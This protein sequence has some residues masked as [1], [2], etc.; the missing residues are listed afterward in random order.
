MRR[1]DLPLKHVRLRQGPIEYRAAGPIDAPVLIFVHGVLAND[2]LWSA[3]VPTLSKSYRC[4]VPIWPLGAHRLAMN[5]AADLTPSGMLVV[6]ED[7]MDAL[8]VERATF[9]GNDSGG[10]LCQ[11]LVAAHPQR[12]ERL[13]LTSSDAYTIWLPWMFKYLEFAAF[14]PGMLYLLAQF[15]R[16]RWLRRL[17]FAFGWLS[18]RM[19]QSISDAFAE[20]L[21]VSAGVRRD[22]AK[23]LRGISPRLT[24]TAARAFS[25]FPRPVLI[26]WSRDDRF[27]PARHAEILARAFPNASLRWI[28][29]AYTFS[30]ID[31]P[32]QVA[33]AITH[34]L[35]SSAPEAL[36][37]AA[38][39]EHSYSAIH[40]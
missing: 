40:T 29:D 15:M 11:M 4:I 8:G 20:P 10:A 2:H 12:V 31:Q 32:Q 27:F 24:C 16:L 7:L 34:F 36:P 14:I 13:I 30:P 26:A 28:E 17:P 38:G 19:P 21:A 3:L 39:I 22:A 35:R 25:S 33:A 9:V 18:K 1:I 6:I 23:F 5:A 37:A